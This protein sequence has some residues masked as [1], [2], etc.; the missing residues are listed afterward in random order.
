[1]TVLPT[2]G[3]VSANLVCDRRGH[4]DPIGRA[5]SLELLPGLRSRRI[6]SAE[7]AVDF[8]EVREALCRSRRFEALIE[9]RGVPG[10]LPDARRVRPLCLDVRDALRIGLV[11]RCGVLCEEAVEV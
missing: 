11:G 2:R 10:P 8:A 7:R 5:R 6:T 9:E 1:S 4:P 3:D